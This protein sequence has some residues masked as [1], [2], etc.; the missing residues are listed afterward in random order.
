M[1]ACGPAIPLEGYDVSRLMTED[2]SKCLIGRIEHRVGNADPSMEGM[3]PSQTAG[4]PAT[5]LDANGLLKLGP[6][7]QPPQPAEKLR[8]L[9]QEKLLP[10]RRSHVKSVAQSTTPAHAHQTLRR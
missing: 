5:D 2:L 9:G 1:R 8:R 6:L 3:G 7:P 10:L 4:K